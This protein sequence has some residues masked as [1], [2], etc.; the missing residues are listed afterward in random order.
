[1]RHSFKVGDPVRFKC[2]AVKGIYVITKIKGI[3][4]YLKNIATDALIGRH[5]ASDVTL[6]KE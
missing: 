2:G 4:V 1:M 3:Y 5:D 6:I